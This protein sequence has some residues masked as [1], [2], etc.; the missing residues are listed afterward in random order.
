MRGG[1]RPGAG[2]PRG[3]RN[4]KTLEQVQAVEQGGITPLEYL[5]QVMRDTNR[6]EQVRLEAAKAA[7]PFVPCEARGDRVLRGAEAAG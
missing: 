1:S 7:A 3:S 5:L 2:R 6:D 4:Q